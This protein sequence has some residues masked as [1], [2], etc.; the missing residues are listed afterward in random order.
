M[1]QPAD[2]ALSNASKPDPWPKSALFVVPTVE[3]MGIKR[4]PQTEVDILYRIKPLDRSD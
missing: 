1:H 2:E 3:E 4:S